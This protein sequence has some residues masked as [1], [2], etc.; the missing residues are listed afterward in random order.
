MNFVVGDT[1]YVPVFLFMYYKRMSLIMIM[2][3]NYKFG[4]DDK[5]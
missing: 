2:I 5:L 1:F 3:R 4:A